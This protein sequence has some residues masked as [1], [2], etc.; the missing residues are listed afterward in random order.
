[1]LCSTLLDPS[2]MRPWH[3]IAEV[4]QLFNFEH[5]GELVN[6]KLGAL[7]DGNSLEM[8]ARIGFGPFESQEKRFQLVDIANQFAVVLHALP[9]VSQAS[10]DK[11]IQALRNFASEDMP[12]PPPVVPKP[13]M[14]IAIH[15]H[16]YNQYV[17]MHADGT[18]HSSNN[19]DFEQGLPAGWVSERWTVVDAGQ[20][21]IG[22]HHQSTN[23][24]LCNHEGTL[25]GTH[26]EYAAS[27]F[28]KEWASCRWTVVSGAGYYGLFND[29]THRLL[30]VNAGHKTYASSVVDRDEPIQATWIRQHLHFQQLQV[31]LKPGMLIGL[32]H[33]GFKSWLRMQNTYLDNPSW[34][35]WPLSSFHVHPDDWKKETFQVVDAGYGEI[36]L[37]NPHYGRYVGLMEDGTVIS[38]EQKHELPA[39]WTWAR[40]AVLP[41]GNGKIALYNP[42]SHRLLR[43]RGHD[44]RGGIDAS[45]AVSVQYMHDQGSA[46]W[47]H[48]WQVAEPPSTSAPTSPTV[49]HGWTFDT[50]P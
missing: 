34:V 30:S 35:Q 19:H 2:A 11:A 21:A 50:S 8:T 18:V 40:F 5:P 15:N 29:H 44:S 25:S 16:Y 13:G 45:S 46:W 31:F 24:I 27:D 7:L 47:W 20:G 23:R 49:P 1:M 6:F 32:W 36:A 22:L 33:P 4:F 9:F 10:R 39:D 41:L 37:Y 3:A 48:I 28:R 14:S 38:S 42:A 43:G 17:N 12:P 26:E